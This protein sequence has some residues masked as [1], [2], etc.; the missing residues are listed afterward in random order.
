[1][2]CLYYNTKLIING[3]GWDSKP[4]KEKSVNTYNKI[5]VKSALMSI[6]DNLLANDV[7]AQKDMDLLHK[8]SLYF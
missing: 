7:I 5:N 2:D 8:W 4:L 1:M 3:L 6:Y